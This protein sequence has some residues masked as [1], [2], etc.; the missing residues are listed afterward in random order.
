VAKSYVL[1]TSAVFA[2]TQAEEGSDVI[3]DILTLAD[4]EK[5][6]EI[7]ELPYKLRKS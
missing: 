6:T 2:F 7:L 3:E 5:C 1:D 4:K